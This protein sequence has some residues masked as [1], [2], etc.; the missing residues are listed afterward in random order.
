MVILVPVITLGF[1]VYL[2][3]LKLIFCFSL[4]FSNN[5]PAIITTYSYVFIIMSGPLLWS[6]LKQLICFEAEKQ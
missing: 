6:T 1:T 3:L 2:L 4:H 5:N